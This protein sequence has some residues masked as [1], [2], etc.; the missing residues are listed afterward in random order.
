MHL[1]DNQ[2]W[3]IDSLIFAN[4]EITLS[5]EG[6]IL[7]KTTSP[8]RKDRVW[9]VRNSKENGGVYVGGWLVCVTVEVYEGSG[10]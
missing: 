7:K 3:T 5:N 6:G 4:V 10:V 1:V 8:R 2:A 9:W